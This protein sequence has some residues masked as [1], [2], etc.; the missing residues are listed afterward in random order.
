MLPNLPMANP[1]LLDKNDV[2]PLHLA[3]HH[4]D[5]PDIINLLLEAKLKESQGDEKRLTSWKWQ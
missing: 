4:S 5:K 3:F 2:S 1:N